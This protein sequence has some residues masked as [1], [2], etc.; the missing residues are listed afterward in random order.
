MPQELENADA[1]PSGHLAQTGDLVELEAVELMLALESQDVLQSGF[2]E[3][4]LSAAASVDG[5]LLFHVPAPSSASFQRAA[6]VSLPTDAGSIV[7]LAALDEAGSAIELQPETP[8][9]AHLF[10]LGEAYLEVATRFRM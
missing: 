5:E 9:T 2:E 7:V 8:E 1:V 6:L 10:R 4:V 3:S